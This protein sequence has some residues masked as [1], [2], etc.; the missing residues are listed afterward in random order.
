MK[1]LYFNNRISDF[2]HQLPNDPF[3]KFM[4]SLDLLAVRGY[5]LRMPHSKSIGN[6]L[7]ELRVPSRPPIRAIFGFH[8]DRALIIHIFFKKTM[9][10]PRSEIDYAVRLWKSIVA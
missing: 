10:I 7:F 4:R 1:V 9:R 2:I 6:E 5:E 3:H 8:E